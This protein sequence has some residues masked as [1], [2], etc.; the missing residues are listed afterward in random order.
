MADNFYL[1]PEGMSRATGKLRDLGNRLE[2]SFKKLEGVLDQH[3]GCWGG[4][5]IG[6]A[7][8]KNYVPAATEARKGAGDAA[9]AIVQTSDD[10]DKS[11]KVFQSVDEKEAQRIDASTGQS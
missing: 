7:F 5:D 10:A 6:K 9:H 2:G 1:D 11:S 4:D 8:E 3:D